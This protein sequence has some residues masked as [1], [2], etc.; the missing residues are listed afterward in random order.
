MMHV[1]DNDNNH[2]DPVSIRSGVSRLTEFDR[3]SFNLYA[4]E[5]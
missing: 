1:A 4:M 5:E 2:R 3:G